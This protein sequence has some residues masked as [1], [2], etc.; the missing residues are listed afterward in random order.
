MF[1]VVVNWLIIIKTRYD[2]LQYNE[3]MLCISA[4]TVRKTPSQQLMG[5]VGQVPLSSDQPIIGS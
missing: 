2:G 1:S 5:V 3:P 4:I